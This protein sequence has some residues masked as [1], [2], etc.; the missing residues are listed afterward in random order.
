MIEA[1]FPEGSFFRTLFSQDVSSGCVGVKC[2]QRTQVDKIVAGADP[3]ALGNTATPIPP[4]SPHHSL[5]RDV[6][7]FPSFQHKIILKGPPGP[8]VV[9]ICHALLCCDQS[10]QGQA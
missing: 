9:Q 4:S 7:C 3:H 8:D 5:G 10:P 6:Q 2:I 1:A